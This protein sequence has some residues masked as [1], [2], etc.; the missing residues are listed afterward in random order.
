MKSVAVSLHQLPHAEVWGHG[1]DVIGSIRWLWR[2][3]GKHVCRLDPAREKLLMITG[4]HA[5]DQ[6]SVP[7]VRRIEVVSR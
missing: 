5:V 3:Y 7:G 2:Q 6:G 1:V 4:L